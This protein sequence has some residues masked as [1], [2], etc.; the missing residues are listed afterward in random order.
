VKKCIFLMTA[1]FSVVNVVYAQAYKQDTGYI[2]NMYVSL[3]GTISIGLD[4]GFPNAN[5][6]GACPSNNGFAGNSGMSTILK[7]T[8]IAAKSSETKIIVTTLGCEAGGSWHKI[9]D[10]YIP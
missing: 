4:Q 5:A 9:I 7:A 2:K 3:T 1:L 6:G 10:V 8:L